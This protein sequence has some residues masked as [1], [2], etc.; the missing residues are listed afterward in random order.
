MKYLQRI[1][2]FDDERVAGRLKRI[3]SKG[4]LLSYEEI[5]YRQASRQQ[6]PGCKVL[7]T[8]LSGPAKNRTWI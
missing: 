8:Y 1:A 2:C 3:S 4:Q 6:E 5:R 7:E